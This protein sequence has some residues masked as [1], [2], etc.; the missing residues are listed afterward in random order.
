M[1]LWLAMKHNLSSNEVIL[2]AR[3]LDFAKL[4]SVSVRTVDNWIADG[5]IPVRKYGRKC[6]RIPIAKAEEA[7]ERFESGGLA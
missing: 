1:T 6:V 5:I 2:E 4:K 7:L 3:R